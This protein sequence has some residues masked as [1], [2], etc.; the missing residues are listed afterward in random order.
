M[1]QQE[2]Q[3]ISDLAERIRSATAPHIDPDADDLIRRAIGIRPDALY[4]LTQTVLVQDMALNQAKARI[5]QLEQAT[6]SPQAGFLPG[7]AGYPQQGFSQSGYAQ[8]PYAQPVYAEP[9]P[10]HGGFSNFLHN[11]AT[12]A[13]GVL[14]GEI[15][16]ESLS[17]IFLGGRGGFFGGGIMPGSETIV[18]NYN[19]DEQRQG[20]DNA[21]GDSRF[22]QVADHSDPGIS[23]DVEDDRDFSG[24]DSSGGF[25]SGGSGDSF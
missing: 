19:G 11:A 9:Q 5:Q 24:D 13:A 12:T 18:N 25:D 15:A 6:Q 17:S 2:Q 16:F 10:Q 7:Q 14:A 4:I 22:A 20:F 21:G 1:N 23:P 3:L 8:S